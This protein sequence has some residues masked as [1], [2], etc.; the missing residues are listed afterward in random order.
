MTDP[1]DWNNLFENASQTINID[2]DDEENYMKTIV[3]RTIGT[4][5]WK[6]YTDDPYRQPRL[7]LFGGFQFWITAT[8]AIFNL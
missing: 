6:H 3:T 1:D 4:I 8:I 2:L 5:L 7:G